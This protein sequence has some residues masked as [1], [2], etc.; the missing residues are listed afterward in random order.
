[1]CGVCFLLFFVVGFIGFIG[2][3]GVLGFWGFWVFGGVFGLFLGIVFGVVFWRGSSVVY[4]TTRVSVSRVGIVDGYAT[5]SITIHL[6]T[7]ITKNIT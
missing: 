2:F 7:T 3:F 6:L 4:F 1:M 5:I